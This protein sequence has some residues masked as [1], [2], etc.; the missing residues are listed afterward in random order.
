MT[1]ATRVDGSRA[2]VNTRDSGEGIDPNFLPHIF[3]P[4]SQGAS[5]TM[6]TGLGLG[7]CDRETAGRSAWRPHHGRKPGRREGR[8]VYGVNSAGGK[9]GRRV[10][11]LVEA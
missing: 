5:K 4:F 2:V 11:S 3:E 9:R 8:V 7:L 1:I 10:H 6:R